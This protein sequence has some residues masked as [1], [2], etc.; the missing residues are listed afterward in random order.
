MVF[1]NRQHS[2]SINQKPYQ[3]A[4]ENY[5]SRLQGRSSAAQ[6]AVKVRFKQ[7]EVVEYKLRKAQQPKCEGPHQAQYEQS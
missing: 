7:V 1:S 6:R 2:V 5:S 3:I 4:K